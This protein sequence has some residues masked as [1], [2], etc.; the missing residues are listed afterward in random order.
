[1]FTHYWVVNHL[2]AFDKHSVHNIV[3]IDWW[4]M[5]ELLL[6]IKHRMHYS[7]LLCMLFPCLA[8]IYPKIGKIPT[9]VT[10]IVLLLAILM[11][12]SRI[13]WIY[14]IVIAIITIGWIVLPGKKGWI[15][16]NDLKLDL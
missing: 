7:S 11:T 13:A 16:E 1:M 2:Y 14:F 3:D 5:S 8:I 9:I 15:K 10:S 4:H 6:N 12:G